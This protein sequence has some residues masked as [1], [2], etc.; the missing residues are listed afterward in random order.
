[1]EQIGVSREISKPF[2]F[3][4]KPAPSLLYRNFMFIHNYPNILEET[5]FK[6]DDIELVKTNHPHGDYRILSFV[7]AAQ[8]E[9]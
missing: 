2:E 3:S 6:P 1:M 5:G 8:R 4:D 7:A 9:A